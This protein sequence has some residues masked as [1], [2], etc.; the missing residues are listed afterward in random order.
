[1]THTDQERIVALAG[2]HQAIHCLQ[3]IATRGSVAAEPMQPCIYSL[4]QL[5]APDVP[6]VYGPPGAVASGARHIVAQIT[7]EPKR[8]L[9]MTRYLIVLMHHERLLNE[10]DEL[11]TALR[12]GLEALN[13]WRQERAWLDEELLARLAALYG[14]TVGRLQPR[15]MVHGNPLYLRDNA[16]Q[17]RVRALLL[18]GIRAARLWRQLGGTRWMLLFHRRR[19]LV[20][21]RD[22]L[23]AAEDTSPPL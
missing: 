18:A 2:L 10:H 21:A 9:D 6:A 19:L 12:A 14:T 7:G 11:L 4:F 1:M 15:I 13:A 5:D 8:D 22:Y 23:A 17:D 20:A 3:C 16:H